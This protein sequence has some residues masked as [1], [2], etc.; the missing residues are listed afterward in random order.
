VV[1]VEEVAPDSEQGIEFSEDYETDPPVPVEA[2]GQVASCARGRDSIP[3]HVTELRDYTVMR[4]GIDCPRCD[5]IVFY[6]PESIGP[7]N[8]VRCFN[9]QWS[10]LAIAWWETP[11]LSSFSESNN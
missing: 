2:K 4:A 10:P 6:H 5:S 8:T 9:C 3:E 1:I 7:P 11:S